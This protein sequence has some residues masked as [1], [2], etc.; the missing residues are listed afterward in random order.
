M[1]ECSGENAFTA[2]RTSRFMSVSREED[3]TFEEE[4]SE[5]RLSFGN[6]L[7]ASLIAAAL[8]LSSSRSLHR[9]VRISILSVKSFLSVAS[10]AS[11]SRHASRSIF[12]FSFSNSSGVNARVL[13][14]PFLTCLLFRE[15][16]GCGTVGS[17][18][19]NL[20]DKGASN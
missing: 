2:F 4:D 10:F 9:V 5:Q 14:F 6:A 13:F 3:P 1:L 19:G 18:S 12:R 11:S 16:S 8:F 15:R 17:G 7:G 20:G